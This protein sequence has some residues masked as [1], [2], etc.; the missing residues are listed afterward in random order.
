METPIQVFS[1][2]FFEI[3]RNT[4][5]IEPLGWLL[6]WFDI[7]RSYGSGFPSIM[8]LF[9]FLDLSC[10]HNILQPTTKRNENRAFIGFRKVVQGLAIFCNRLH[11]KL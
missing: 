5:F 1:R 8:Y 9:W 4:F 2:E 3:S 6:I 7:K 11:G 10:Q